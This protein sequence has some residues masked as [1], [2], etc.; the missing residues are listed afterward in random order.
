MGGSAVPLVCPAAAVP[1]SPLV[2]SVAVPRPVPPVSGATAGL[3][4]GGPAAG[5]APQHRGPRSAD[6][7]R[8]AATLPALPRVSACGAI[9]GGGA[10]VLWPWR[11]RPLRVFL[12]FVSVPRG[13]GASLSAPAFPLRGAT[14][15][16]A[17]AVRRCTVRRSVPSGAFVFGRRP[18]TSRAV[19]FERFVLASCIRAAAGRGRGGGGA[20]A[21]SSLRFAM[22]SVS[23]AAGLL[24]RCP[25]C[26]PRGRFRAPLV[27]PSDRAPFPRLAE[28]GRPCVPLGVRSRN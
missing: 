7:G 27:V 26:P 15:A 5:A 14:A 20:A 16:V 9:R 19:S 17:L 24:A 11:P 23:A 1:L 21:A 28:L 12:S 2:V 6:G 8:S 22:P 10:P 3:V 18:R 4:R 13:P 25:P